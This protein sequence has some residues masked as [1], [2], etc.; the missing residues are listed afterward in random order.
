MQP[1]RKR[2]ELSRLARQD[3]APGRAPHVW[4]AGQ[5]GRFLGQVLFYYYFFTL[6]K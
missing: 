5:L 4:D 2:E 6:N 1:S 3:A